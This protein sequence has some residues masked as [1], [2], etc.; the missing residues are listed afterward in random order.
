[1]FVQDAITIIIF[2]HDCIFYFL[3]FYSKYTFNI[4]I[5]RLYNHWQD[6]ATN[7]VFSP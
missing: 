2:D 1:M 5:V 3:C 6:N 7:Q 4:I